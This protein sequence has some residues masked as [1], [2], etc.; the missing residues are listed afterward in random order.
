MISDS[1]SDRLAAP[2]FILP[3]THTYLRARTQIR[4]QSALRPGSTTSSTPR[5]TR[6][7]LSAGRA[8]TRCIPRSQSSRG[9]FWCVNLMCV[10]CVCICVYVS[11]D[12]TNRLTNEEAVS[13]SAP[14]SV[15]LSI[16]DRQ[17]YSGGGSTIRLTASAMTTD[18]DRPLHPLLV[19]RF[20]YAFNLY[21][22]I[23][24]ATA[25]LDR[26]TIATHPC[27]PPISKSV[28]KPQRRCV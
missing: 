23:Y 3:S 21:M 5:S 26:M 25:V 8:R 28:W 1:D 6:D 19:S 27:L 16:T 18:M 13:E 12:R 14:F 15:T 17:H 24:H 4:G 20:A 10:V 11:I 22:H 2:T 9:A 7:T